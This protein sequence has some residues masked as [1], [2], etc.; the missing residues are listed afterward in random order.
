MKILR[1]KVQVILVLLMCFVSIKTFSVLMP[2]PKE[3]DNKPSQNSVLPPMGTVDCK[4]CFKALKTGA[5]TGDLELIEYHKR[6][7][8]GG[9]RNLNTPQAIEEEW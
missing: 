3:Q 8:L 1:I 9:D 5:N 4:G 6:Q 2:M 7:I